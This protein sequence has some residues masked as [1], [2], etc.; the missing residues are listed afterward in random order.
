MKFVT[1]TATPDLERFPEPER[2]R[3]WCSTHKRLMRTDSEYRR[4]MH[5]F[6]WKIVGTTIPFVALSLALDRFEWPPF[7]VQLPAYLVL[8]TIYVIYILRTSLSGQRFQNE[9]VGKALHEHVA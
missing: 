5:G 1:Y 6:R 2:F 3:V 9:R 4:Q 7:V 8:T